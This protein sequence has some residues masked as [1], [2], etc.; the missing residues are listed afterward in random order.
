[1]IS[2]PHAFGGILEYILKHTD[3]GGLEIKL[4]LGQ[5]INVSIDRRSLS[6]PF[7]F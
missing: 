7:F 5:D 3:I 4:S 6:R 2:L 1:V